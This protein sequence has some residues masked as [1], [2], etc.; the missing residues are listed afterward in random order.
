MVG[1]A[2]LTSEQAFAEA[3]AAFQKEQ[4]RSIPSA[5]GYE[6]SDLGRV[7]GVDRVVMRGGRPMRVRGRL[8]APKMA[9]RDGRPRVQLGSATRLIHHLVLE[10]FVGPRPSGTEACHNNGDKLDN[11]ASNLRWDTRSSNMR[12][13]VRHGTHRTARRTHCPRGHVLALPNLTAS[14]LPYRQCL[15][16][17]RAR[18]RLQWLRSKGQ[19]GDLTLL[20]DG[21][22]SEVM[23]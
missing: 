7:R 2:D 8:L 15:A 18:A 23:A 4:W 10:A 20:A 22:Y 17:N 3:L 9:G 11:R 1:S 19:T 13:T 6:V 21:Y 14:M 16:C 5:P 12:D